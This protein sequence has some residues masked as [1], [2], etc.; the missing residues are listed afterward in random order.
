MALTPSALK[1]LDGLCDDYFDDVF[2]N[3]AMDASV[4]DFTLP[5]SFFTLSEV[6]SVTYKGEE[7]SLEELNVDHDTSSYLRFPSLYEDVTENL[8]VHVDGLSFSLEDF[9]STGLTNPSLEESG[10]LESSESLFVTDYGKL[11]DSLS[12]FYVV[13]P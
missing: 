12:V 1:E 5:L 6:L 8:E 9:L 7:L 3:R 2:S 13:L 4:E 11:G 10:S